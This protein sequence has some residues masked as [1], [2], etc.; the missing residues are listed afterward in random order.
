MKSRACRRRNLSAAANAVIE[1]LGLSEKPRNVHRRPCLSFLR[2]QIGACIDI[3]S[4]GALG[5]WHAKALGVW[6]YRGF[7]GDGEAASGS[8]E[9]R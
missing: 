7:G 2:H 1:C 3:M 6:Y 8:E 5:A 4:A 9:M